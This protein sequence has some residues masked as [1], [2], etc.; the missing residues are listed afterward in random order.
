MPDDWERATERLAR[1]TVERR[2]EW[3]STYE[4]MS[5]D[6]MR[7]IEPVFM[8]TVNDRRVAVYEYQYQYFTDEDEWKWKNEVVVEFVHCVNGNWDL[9]YRW[10]QV[11]GRLQLLEAIRYQ[12]SNADK[13]LKEFL[14]EE[15]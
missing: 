5:R 13:F 14:A 3:E 12:V 1:L 2:L 8:T 9:E 11:A 6:D 4:R 7:V 15:S 10:P